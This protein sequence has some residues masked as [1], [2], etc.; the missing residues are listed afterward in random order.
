MQVVVNLSSYKDLQ[1]FMPGCNH[2]LSM[3][4]WAGLMNIQALFKHDPN[5]HD[6]TGRRHKNHLDSFEAT[7]S[8]LYPT[9][10][11]KV[12]SRLKEWVAKVKPHEAGRG[13][14]DQ[15]RNPWESSGG[16]GG[17]GNGAFY[18]ATSD[19]RHQSGPAVD[20]GLEY[21]P[22]STFP[23]GGNI[24]LLPPTD[25]LGNGFGTGGDG[26]PAAVPFLGEFTAQEMAAFEAWWFDMLEV[27]G[28][29]STGGMT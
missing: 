14:L 22:L 13:Q 27:D 10:A 3:F 21:P 26:M 24:G 8:R 25:F 9:T 5:A 19:L 23:A 1:V 4:A 20:Y 11:G 18:P 2:T 15:E 28:T 16:A 7:L 29:P 12:M 17:S 6:W